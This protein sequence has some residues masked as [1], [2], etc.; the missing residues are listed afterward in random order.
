MAAE[1]APRP[2]HR[3]EE[4]A[5]ARPDAIQV[6]L[7]TDI[8]GDVDDVIALAFCALHPRIDLL[9][10][11][12]VNGDCKRRARLARSLLDL[13]GCGEVPVGVGASVGLS[14][15]G[16]ATMPAGLNHGADL[17]DATKLVPTSASAVLSAALE[18]APGPV[19]VCTI[20]A[21]TNVAAT[22]S[23]RPDLLDRV[24]GL[25]VMGGC[26]GPVSFGD[27]GDPPGDPFSETNLGGDPLA[28]AILWALPLPMRLVPLDVTMPLAFTN[29]D[30]A[31]IAGAGPVGRVLAGL[32][33][34][35]L[36]AERQAGARPAEL[37]AVRLHDPLTVV[38]LAVP[39]VETVQ[40]RHLA[41]FG[42]PGKVRTVDAAH[43]R[44]VV[45]CRGAD[46]ARLRAVLVETLGA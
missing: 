13:L 27:G 33:D 36:A 44:P 2:I 9:C 42:S 1:H 7:D 29:D 20:G 45:A 6:V 43:G 5:T 35:Y 22:L 40:L 18:Q 8:G 4:P 26:L 25:H 15:R 10:V 34:E 30:R 38:G 28:T 24:A 41:A 3:S 23:A 46:G 14:G 31:T 21:V 19:E 32:M 39:E 37:A 12:T 16:H 11:T 17:I